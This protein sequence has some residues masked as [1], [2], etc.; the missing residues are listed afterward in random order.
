MVVILSMGYHLCTFE[1]LM[2][3]IPDRR[4]ISLFIVDGLTPSKG[5]F[6]MF[7]VMHAYQVGS[8]LDHQAHSLF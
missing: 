2:L 8:L 7:K 5:A 1:F 3:I 4:Y 6:S